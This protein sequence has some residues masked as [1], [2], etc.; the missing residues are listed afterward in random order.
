MERIIKS[1]KKR[2]YREMWQETL[3]VPNQLCLKFGANIKETFKKGKHTSRTQEISK[4]W[5][6]KLKGK[7]EN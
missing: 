6:R 2:I 3:V 4:H 7:I 5:D 1:L